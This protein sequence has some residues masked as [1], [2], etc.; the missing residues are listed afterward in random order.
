MS[1]VYYTVYT[2]CSGPNACCEGEKKSSAVPRNRISFRNVLV[3]FLKNVVFLLL[4]WWGV[5]LAQLWGVEV[6]QEIQSSVPI[7]D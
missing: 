1:T 2:K 3:S 4:W 6:E 5:V 7:R